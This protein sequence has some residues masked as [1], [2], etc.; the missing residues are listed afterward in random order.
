[1]CPI[2]PA[3]SSS[4]P[5]LSVLA[6]VFTAPRRASALRLG[7]VRYSCVRECHRRGDKGTRRRGVTS[8]GDGLEGRAQAALVAPAT[9][10]HCGRED[11]RY[12]TTDPSRGYHLI[13]DRVART[14]EVIW[15]ELLGDPRNHRSSWRDGLEGAPRRWGPLS[16]SGHGHKVPSKK[17]H[18]EVVEGSDSLLSLW[19]KAERLNL[20]TV[21]EDELPTDRWGRHEGLGARSGDHSM[22]LARPF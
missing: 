12:G 9:P 11:V 18:A 13:G 7:R 21:V 4:C 5:N 20:V 8:S 15:L 3:G 10:D 2:A 1:M 22:S 14:T 17:P 6:A 19:L 16:G